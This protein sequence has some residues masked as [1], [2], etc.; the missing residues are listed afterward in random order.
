[1][2]RVSS[3][4]RTEC[5][6][7]TSDHHPEFSS[8]NVNREPLLSNSLLPFTGTISGGGEAVDLADGLKDLICFAFNNLS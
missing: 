5:C 8:S 2:P 1:M 4:S 7:V 6:S 3:V